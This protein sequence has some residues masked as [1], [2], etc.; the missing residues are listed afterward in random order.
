MN[1]Q[2]EHLGIPNGNVLTIEAP[3]HFNYRESL[4]ATGNPLMAMAA[5]QARFNAAEGFFMPWPRLTAGR[6]DGN[7]PAPATAY[8]GDD[9]RAQ[10]SVRNSLD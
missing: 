8:R 1:S 9:C 3:V 7:S 5:L 10:G 2:A 4:L 6:P